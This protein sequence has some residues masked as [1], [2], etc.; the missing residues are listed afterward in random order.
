MLGTLSIT[1]SVCW[2]RLLPFLLRVR[3]QISLILDCR[4]LYR[5]GSCRTGWSKREMR[6]AV[7][8]SGVSGCWELAGTTVDFWELL[9]ILEA[10][11][12]AVCFWGC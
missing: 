7:G 11:G 10:A 2:P 4:F 6:D 1:I 9:E 5:Y 12:E 3:G 8:C